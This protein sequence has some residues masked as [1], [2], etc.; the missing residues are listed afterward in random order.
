[1]KKT[2]IIFTITGAIIGAIHIFLE[3][4]VNYADTAPI[5]DAAVIGFDIFSPNFLLTLAIYMVLYGLSG[6]ILSI[7]LLYIKKCF[8]NKK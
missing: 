2:V 4:A 5:G 7:L 6:W 3:F 1:M 8:S